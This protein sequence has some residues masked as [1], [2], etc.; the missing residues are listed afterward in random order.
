LTALTRNDDQDY[1]PHQL[2]QPYQ[3]CQL[4]YLPLNQ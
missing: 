4:K 2:Y 1:Q 3:P